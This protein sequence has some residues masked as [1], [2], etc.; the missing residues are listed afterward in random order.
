[1]V[2]PPPT[3]LLSPD[4]EPST[5]LQQAIVQIELGGSV[6]VKAGGSLVVGN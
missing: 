6:R 1:M 3:V 5:P 4:S 2:P